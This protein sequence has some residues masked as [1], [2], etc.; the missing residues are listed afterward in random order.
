MDV[1]PPW[2]WETHEFYS[3]EKGAAQSSILGHMFWS[4]GFPIA[5]ISQPQ[6]EG[7]LIP[8]VPNAWIREFSTVSGRNSLKANANTGRVTRPP[9]CRFWNFV[10]TGIHNGPVTPDLAFMLRGTRVSFEKVHTH[11]KDRKVVSLFLSNRRFIG[12]SYH[13]AHFTISRN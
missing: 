1:W 7:R 12:Q 2:F 4:F 11:T 6:T 10:G 5:V 3:Q 13:H 8:W 9:F